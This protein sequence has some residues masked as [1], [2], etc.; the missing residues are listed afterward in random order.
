MSDRER[1]RGGNN[2]DWG[3]FV[4]VRPT[5]EGHKIIWGTIPCPPNK[6]VFKW[7]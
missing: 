2:V 6:L 5:F 3:T 7:F 1:E 4:N